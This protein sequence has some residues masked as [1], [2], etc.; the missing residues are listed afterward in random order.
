MWFRWQPQFAWRTLCPVL[1]A[2]PIGLLV[3]MPRAS[4]PVS[5]EQVDSL[6]DYYP[7]ITAETKHQDY[8]VLEQQIVA[9]DYGLPFSD[10]V[11]QRRAQ[12]QRLRGSQATEMPR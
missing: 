7:D 9:L 10:A 11:E 3:V 1:F 2:D 5:Q 12:Y 4:Q 8:G 6:P